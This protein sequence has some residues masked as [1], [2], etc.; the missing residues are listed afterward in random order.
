[1]KTD[2]P[3]TERMFKEVQAF[4]ESCNL[5]DVQLNYET[6]LRTNPILEIEVG[7]HAPEENYYD[8][9]EFW[10]E[11]G[12]NHEDVFKWYV[13]EVRQIIDRRKREMLGG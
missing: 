5:R 12:A 2:R 6:T 1:M 8:C 10:L 13:G 7:F 4:L 9:I 11:E 3:G